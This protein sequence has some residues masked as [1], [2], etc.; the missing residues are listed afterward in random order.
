MALFL[1][2]MLNSA[3]DVAV[4]FWFWKATCSASNAVLIVDSFLIKCYGLFD[5]SMTDL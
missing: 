2:S 1:V 4:M 5:F 3:I